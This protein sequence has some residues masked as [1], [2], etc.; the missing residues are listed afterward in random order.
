MENDKAKFKKQFVERLINFS[1]SIIDLTDDFPEKA[2]YW[3]I[4]D[5]IIRSATSIGANVVEA[6]SSSSKRDYIK[7]FEIALK[8]ANE[9]EYWLLLIKKLGM[10]CTK[11]MQENKEISSIIA[12]SLL[13]LKNKRQIYN[14]NLSF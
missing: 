9:T 12:S 2:K 8:S 6:R 13:T 1:I 7:F 3:P 10:N 4:R 11:E 14:F 5:Q